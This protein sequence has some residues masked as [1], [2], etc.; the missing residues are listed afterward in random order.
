MG[1]FCLCHSGVDVLCRY[2]ICLTIVWC[3]VFE[4]VL[5]SPSSPSCSPSTSSPSS[6]STSWTTQH[7]RGHVLYNISRDPDLAGYD[8]GETT[9]SEKPSPAAAKRPQPEPVAQSTQKRSEK[10]AAQ[11]P[12]KEGSKLDH[13]R[14]YAKA[15]QREDKLSEIAKLSGVEKQLR[16][17]EVS[18]LETELRDAYIGVV[19]LHPRYALQKKVVYKLWQRVYAGLDPFLQQAKLAKQMQET[20]T[21]GHAQEH[22]QHRFELDQALEAHLGKAERVLRYLGEKLL[23]VQ[24]KRRERRAGTGEASGGASGSDWDDAVEEVLGEL[25]TC[26]G[27]LARYRLLYLPQQATEGPDAGAEMQAVEWYREALSRD[28]TKGKAHNQLAVLANGRKKA[29]AALAHFVMALTVRHPFPARENLLGLYEENRKATAEMMQALD[30][31]GVYPL[32][33]QVWEVM[34]VRL[35]SMSDTH[36]DTERFNVSWVLAMHSLQQLLADQLLEA[37][38]LMDALL[39]LLYALDK[40]LQRSAQQQQQHSQYTD[41]DADLATVAPGMPQQTLELVADVFAAV[42]KQ[43]AS[44]AFR[45]Q[46]Q[47]WE[48]LAALLLY[49][50]TPQ[51]QA[52]LGNQSELVAR[53]KALQELRLGL[54]RFANALQ[55]FPAHKL[56]ASSAPHAA[57]LR[58]R[59]FGPLEAAPAWSALWQAAPQQAGPDLR[60]LLLSLLETL[61]FRVAGRF[62]ARAAAPV[63]IDAAEDA[64]LQRYLQ[65]RKHSMQPRASRPSKANKANKGADKS[66]S[67]LEGGEGKDTLEGGE[68]K[69][70]DTNAGAEEKEEKDASAGEEEEEESKAADASAGEAEDSAQVGLQVQLSAGQEGEDGFVEE[71]WPLVDMGSGDDAGWAEHVDQTRQGVLSRVDVEAWRFERERRRQQ[72][73]A[74]AVTAQEQAPRDLPPAPPRPKPLV[75]LDA[76]NIAMRHGNHKVFSTAGVQLAIE[77]YQRMG[78]PVLAFTPAFHLDY[79]YVSRRKRE[80]NIGMSVRATKMPDNISLLLSLRDEGLLVATPA[81]DYDDS[82]CIEYAMRHGGYIVSNDRYRDHVEGVEP[83]RRA[84]VRAWLKTHLITFAFVKDE[85]LPNPDF[86]P[87]RPYVWLDR[88]LRLLWEISLAIEDGL[89]GAIPRQV[90]SRRPM[91]RDCDKLC[92]IDYCDRQDL[93]SPI[94]VFPLG[95]PELQSRC[96]KAVVSIFTRRRT[97]VQLLESKQKKRLSSMSPLSRSFR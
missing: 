63:V 38:E 75:I 1:C 53:S 32:P 5:S 90:L 91:F 19:L 79:D 13:R 95:F 41:E 47:F 67:T 18:K 28:Y 58:L 23:R 9:Q 43:T 29:L 55:A 44:S 37:D 51:L 68:V 73:L 36:V 3:G 64:E 50:S 48:V 26:L 40:E 24:Q 59:G 94:R 60:A 97:F 33:A 78:H 21:Y 2:T 10:R 16:T 89:G 45:G 12:A 17:A 69:E 81:Q 61:L 86:N 62:S 56:P 42:A 4:S 88:P 76:P 66:A 57:L 8:D 83:S 39:A 22:L 31:R 30:G 77:W 87:A 7:P 70:E 20:G 25:Y 85:F 54:A 72:V 84:A 46:V 34:V 35:V 6:P 82:Y 15:K 52:L 11:Q 80:E 27:D 65:Q 96:R 49:F 71:H 14:L 92:V 93:F 74:A